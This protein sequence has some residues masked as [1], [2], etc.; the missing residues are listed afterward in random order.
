[1]SEA[2]TPAVLDT[3]LPAAISHALRAANIAF[4]LHA[5]ADIDAALQVQTVVLQD[6]AKQS[7]VVFPRQHILDLSQLNKATSAHWRAASAATLQRCL[8]QHAVAEVI[9]IPQLFAMP[10]IYDPV[11]LDRPRLYLPYPALGLAIG[12][13]C[14]AVKALL[15]HSSALSCSAELSHQNA[16][17]SP[18]TEDAEGIQH[19]VIRLTSRRIHQRLQETLDIPLLSTTAQKILRLQAHADDIDIDELIRIVETDPALAAQVVSWAASAYYAAPG[20]IR[21]VEDAITRVLGVDLVVNLSIALSLKD[22][23]AMPKEQPQHYTPYWRQA[24]YTGALIEGL[25]RAMPAEHKPESGLAYLAGLLHNFGFS[26]LAYVFPPHFSLV[27]RSLEVNRHLSHSTV[28]SYLLGITREQMGAWLMQCWNI[29]EEL[30]NALRYQDNPDYAGPHASYAN[31]CCLAQRLLAQHGIGS[32]HD[33]SIP[34]ALYARLGL[35][36]ER[37]QQAL[38]RVLDAELALQELAQ[39]FSQ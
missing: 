32:I 11:L 28:E 16:N 38:Q 39:Q 12:L 1:M 21:S 29:P 13:D 15:A 14:H 8:N 26:L 7:L 17:H 4:S 35:S 3:P 19:A 2:H 22:S 25:V 27:C 33:A 9:A 30:V 34:S 20:K 36:A 18:A 24:I 10:C 6:G 37:A 5:L 23:L 31:L